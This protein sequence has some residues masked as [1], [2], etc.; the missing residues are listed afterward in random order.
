MSSLRRILASAVIAAGCAFAQE[1]HPPAAA[2][3]GSHAEPAKK[4]EPK[5][6]EAAKEGVP[7]AH[8]TA[9]HGQETEHASGAHGDPLLP[10]KWLNFGILAAGLGF[11][12][13]KAGGPAFKARKEA[14]LAGLNAAEIRSQQVA[15]EAAL[16]EQ[17]MA[18]LQGVIDEMRRLS[19]QEMQAETERLRADTAQQIAKLEAQSKQEIESAAK[20]ARQELKAFSAQLALDLAQQKVDARLTPEAQSAMVGQFLRNLNKVEKN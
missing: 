11:L 8:G 10:Y 9:G 2:Q 18:G 3:P 12:A 6:G 4:E 16:V 17:R 20:A 14:I 15:A 1:A 7:A 13:V 5:H 19:R